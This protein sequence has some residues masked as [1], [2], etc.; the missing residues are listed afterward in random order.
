[1]V[2]LGLFMLCTSGTNCLIH[3]FGKSLVI[4]VTSACAHG[5]GSADA[6]L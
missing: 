2:E 1:M 5:T 6:T 3:F 4:R